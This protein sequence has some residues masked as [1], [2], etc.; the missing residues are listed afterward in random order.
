MKKMTRQHI[1]ILCIIINSKET[2][3]KINKYIKIKFTRSLYDKQE[4]QDSIPVSLILNTT[5]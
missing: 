4:K 2:Y 3:K 5:Q 1:P